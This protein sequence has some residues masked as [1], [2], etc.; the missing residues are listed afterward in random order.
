M[1]DILQLVYAWL[2]DRRNGRWLI[3]LD[4][5]DDD[6]V[7][8]AADEDS[9]STAQISDI[10]SHTKPLESFLPQTPNR[11]ILIT[12]RNRSAAIN[13]V[14]T[15][16]GI[17]QIKPIDEEDALTLLKTRVPFSESSK[18]DAKALVQALERIPLV[19]THAAAYIDARAPITTMADYLELFR[20]SEAN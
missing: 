2:S 4:N 11:M 20:K 3:I 17:V 19:I 18:A 5:I 13:L 14:G 6:S 7:F 10:T 1:A 9:A 16:D 8:F 15:Y 12:S